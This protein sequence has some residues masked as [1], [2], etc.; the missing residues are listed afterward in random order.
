MRVYAHKKQKEHFDYYFSMATAVTLTPNLLNSVFYIKLFPTVFHHIPLINCSHWMFVYL[1][2]TNIS[3]KK[4][5]HD[6]LKDMSMEYGKRISMR[7]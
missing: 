2:L 4:S 1:A 3:I 5:L 7:Y 6:V